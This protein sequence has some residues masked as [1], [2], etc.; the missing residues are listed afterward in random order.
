M[1]SH[2]YLM[3][4][5][6]EYRQR[7]KESHKHSK[8]AKDYR[9][10]YLGLRK[11]VREFLDEISSVPMREIDCDQEKVDELWE[12]LAKLSAWKAK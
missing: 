7:H 2:D 3:Q 11:V 9:E 10:K 6:Y 5:S 4:T 8:I 12:Q 1:R